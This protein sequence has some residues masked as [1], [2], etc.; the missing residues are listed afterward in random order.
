[1]INFEIFNELP[2]Y[3]GNDWWQ[4]HFAKKFDG[5]PESPYLEVSSIALR[6]LAANMREG[7]ERATAEAVDFIRSVNIEGKEIKKT[8]EIC[9]NLSSELCPNIDIV[10]LQLNYYVYEAGLGKWAVEIIG[11]SSKIGYQGSYTILCNEEK[12]VISDFIASDEFVIAGMHRLF[13]CNWQMERCAM[14]IR[15]W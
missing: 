9:S 11:G 5:A 2:E 12:D 13:D 3:I 15:S 14:D 8:F 6:I 1:M 4:E 7:I 10:K